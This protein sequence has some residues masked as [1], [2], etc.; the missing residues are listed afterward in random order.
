MNKDLFKKGIK[1][2]K[3]VRMTHEERSRLFQSISNYAGIENVTPQKNI[4]WYK[5]D[6][7]I[8]FR[9]T[10][11]LALIVFFFS[12]TAIVFASS[13]SL[14]GDLLYPIKVNVIEP[15]KGSTAITQAAKIE[16]EA[17]KANTR[18]QEAEDLSKEGKLNDTNR[19]EIE[20]RFV[21]HV[22]NFDSFTEQKRG[23][24]EDKKTSDEKK[25]A[26]IDF[27][28]SI[29]EHTEALVEIQA[30]TTPEQKDEVENLKNSVLETVDNIKNRRENRGNRE[31]L[32]RFNN[33]NNTTF[34][35]NKETEGP[36]TDDKNE[37]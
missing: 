37:D 22:K 9:R 28:N 35:N 8:L 23:R 26:R 33:R 16:W 13:S 5:N 20:D 24:T 7:S 6:W 17:E 36:K 32:I 21:E 15:I 14:P 19:K 30:S 25:Q 27:V 34:T 3:N 12:V 29:K 4:I 2:V 18:L 10:G 11:A 31:E 1:D